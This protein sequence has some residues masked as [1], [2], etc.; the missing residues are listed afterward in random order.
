MTALTLALLAFSL[1]PILVGL[2]R[3]YKRNLEIERAE[4]RIRKLRL[5]R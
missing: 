2:W 5:P 3:E 1:P 4:E